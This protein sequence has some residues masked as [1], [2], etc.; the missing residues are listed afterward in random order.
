[1]RWV[2]LTTAPNEPIGQSWVELL[3]KHGLPAYLRTETVATLVSGGSHPVAL[4]VPADRK[5]EGQALFERLVG[6]WEGEG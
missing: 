3:R 4:M 6:P 2:R 1:M 5:Q